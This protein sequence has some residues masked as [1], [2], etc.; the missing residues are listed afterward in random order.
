DH[1]AIEPVAPELG[2]RPARAPHLAER[3]AALRLDTDDVA[4][5]QDEVADQLV[6]VGGSA[7]AQPHAHEGFVHGF[8]LGHAALRATRGISVSTV[9]RGVTLLIS[10]RRAPRHASIARYSTASSG[11]HAASAATA[12]A[13]AGSVSSVGGAPARAS[14]TSRQNSQQPSI[15]ASA[16]S[17]STR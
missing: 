2:H 1:A 15:S 16:R 5:V 4:D 13:R 9:S 17:R 8:E 11:H 3:G 12:S 7:V 14:T 10:A 6:I